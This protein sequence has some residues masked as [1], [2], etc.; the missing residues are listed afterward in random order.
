MRTG[1]LTAGCQE[2]HKRCSFTP[3]KQM[4]R[5]LHV[6]TFVWNHIKTALGIASGIGGLWVGLTADD[7]N[8]GVFGVVLVVLGGQ[9]LICDMLSAA[10]RQAPGRQEFTRGFELGEHKGYEEGRRSV[11]PVVVPLHAGEL[12]RAPF[13]SR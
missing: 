6:K 12:A 3:S 1:S 9:M 2:P 7:R 13:F 10:I 5:G 4:G 8:A 11:R